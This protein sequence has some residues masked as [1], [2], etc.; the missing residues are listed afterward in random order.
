MWNPSV[1]EG[2]GA[3]NLI[4]VY[5]NNTVLYH[6]HITDKNICVSCHFSIGEEYHDIY[7]YIYIFICVCGDILLRLDRKMT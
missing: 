1:R 6:M 2:I 3:I 7:I 4:L 5:A